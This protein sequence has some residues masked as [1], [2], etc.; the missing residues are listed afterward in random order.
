MP[1]AGGEQISRLF[2]APRLHAPI[3]R[4]RH[5]HHGVVGLQFGSDFRFKVLT[6]M[7]ALS[8]GKSL[9]SCILSVSRDQNKS[10][11]QPKILIGRASTLGF[12]TW[13]RHIG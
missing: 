5:H 11:T 1:K 4:T 3:F 13:E 9:W 2:R 6:A 12:G 7:H 10:G 8:F